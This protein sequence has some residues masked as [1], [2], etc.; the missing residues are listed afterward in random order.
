MANSYSAIYFQ[1]KLKLLIKKQ[2]AMFEV[3]MQ[4]TKTLPL[5]MYSFSRGPIPRFG[6]WLAKYVGAMIAVIVICLACIFG[7]PFENCRMSC[8]CGLFS[9]RYTG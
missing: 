6:L 7:G 2:S 3:L 5:L 9:R 1:E 4:F 8:V